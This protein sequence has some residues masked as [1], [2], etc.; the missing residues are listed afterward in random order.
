[1]GCGRKELEEGASLVCRDFAAFCDY[2]TDN[3]VKLAKRTGNI[4]KK[5]CF[6]LNALFYVRENYTQPSNIQNKYPIINFFYYIAVRYKILEIVSPGMTMRRGRRYRQFREASV[7]EQY[8]LF[9]AVFLSDGKFAGEESDWYA[10]RTAEMW[11]LYIDKFMEWV[12][13]EEFTVG[14]V[15]RWEWRQR[16]QYFRFMDYITPYLEELQL[17]R[18]H[19]KPEA[20]CREQEYLWEIEALPLLETVY[21]LYENNLTWPYPDRDSSGEDRMV[22]EAWEA[23]TDRMEEQKTGDFSVL[24]GNA[25][26]ETAKRI[27][28]LEVSVRGTDCIRVLRMRMKDSL[29]DLHRM[30]QR[31]V[32][33]DD[34][35]LYEFCVGT[36]MMKRVYMPPDAIDSGEEQSVEASL[37]SLDLYQGQKFT[38]LFDFGDMWYF[39]IKVLEIREGTVEKP[40]VLRADGD[41]PEQY[42][43]YEEDEEEWEEQEWRVVVSER[44][45]I[46]AI[47]AFLEEDLILDEYAALTGLKEVDEREDADRLRQEMERILLRDPERMLLFMTHQMRKT[48]SDLLKEEWIDGRE[49][50][51]LAK[52]YSFG[53]CMLPEG[54]Q[55]EIMVPTAVKEVYELRIRNDC[56]YDKMAEAAELFL[57]WCG[58]METEVLYSAVVDFLKCSISME[59]FEF[60]VY[61]RLHYFGRYYSVR[62]QETE[63]MSC[64][65]SEIT[66]RILEEREK[67]ENCLFAYPDFTR[68]DARKLRETPKVLQD[69]EEYIE[70]HLNIDWR[71][72]QILME[73]IPA[74]AATGIFK[75]EQIVAAYKDMLR[76]TGSRATKKAESLIGELLMNMPLATRKGNGG[77]GC[78]AVEEKMPEQIKRPEK[79]TVPEKEKTESPEEEYWQMSIFD[80]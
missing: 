53:F 14:R 37:D 11:T 20:D 80:L 44:I 16:R 74:M 48:L 78:G 4:G 18:V 68:M 65:E 45:Q 27:V 64:Y 54:N 29:Y 23:Y 31:A 61:S 13:A 30:I 49:M 24:V 56:K 38:Y 51:T 32:S 5:D 8:A 77:A 70:F 40:E 12:G 35:H 71:T 26:K 21:E 69:W 9:L 79:K 34:D 1:M 19:K 62:L 6:A 67:Q 57:G 47:L 17:I 72:A 43:L 7:W 55:Y 25:A 76:G 33:F 75:R 10:A 28:D 36:G 52:L 41:A 39:D 60:L 50:C 15:C 73:Q 58:V 2:V 3:K 42:P 63:Y 59:N 46:S 22:Q 66:Q